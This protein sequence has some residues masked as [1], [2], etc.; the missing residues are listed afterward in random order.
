MGL[1][2]IPHQVLEA[3]CLAIDLASL[4]HADRTVIGERGVTLSGGQKQR[5]ALARAAYAQPTTLL[6]DDVLSAVDAPTGRFIFNALFGRT[7][8]LLHHTACILITHATQF[9]PLASRCLMLHDGEVI[10]YGS[11]DELRSLASKHAT[12]ITTVTGNGKL[13]SKD[14][15]QAKQQ[16]PGVLDEA[17]GISSALPEKSAEKSAKKSAG[18]KLVAEFL[19]SAVVSVGAGEKAQQQVEGGDGALLA[20]QAER[21]T[22][23]DASIDD[24]LE[25]RLSKQ[26]C[27]DG[28]DSGGDSGSD[29]G[30]D[31]GGDASGRV[32]KHASDSNALSELCPEICPEICPNTP[33]SNTLSELIDQQ[34]LSGA[35]SADFKK[36]GAA[37][38]ERL[39]L[40]SIVAWVGAMGGCSWLLLELAFF[41]G[42]RGTYV[43]ADTWLSVWASASDATVPTNG[44][45]RTIGFGPVGSFDDTRR[46]MIVWA[47]LIGCNAFFAFARTA[48]FVHGGARAAEAIFV[49]LL[50]GIVRSPMAFFD[51]TP[52]G[53]LTAR[54]AYDTE[55]LDGLLVQKGLTVMASIWWL[56]SG[57]SVILSIVTFV[58]VALLPCGLI[59]TT[60]HLMYLRS[61]VQIQRLF[62]QSQSPLVSHIE[63]S[64]AGGATIRSF[65]QSGRFRNRLM[66][67][68]D[69]AS[70]AFVA[71]VAVGRWLAVRPMGTRGPSL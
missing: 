16:S 63:E 44:F 35:A 65:G 60:F 42:E 68:N 23:E 59:Y 28:G 40:H 69:D 71:F 33:A 43:G 70:A 14:D 27:G 2:C 21:I 34:G 51:T 30:S 6:L 32:A 48:W 37:T 5:I 53:R 12:A 54:L 47:I 4:P 8:G 7:S 58:A 55:I 41:V 61:G 66:V 29:S 11:V 17:V 50:H 49:R 45:Y 1:D 67:L 13:A 26:V 3:C 39:G 18:L 15:S 56:I 24:A 31:S 57:L 36:E 22:V 38:E 62:A 52:V 10:G 19:M 64:L 25:D 46:Y 9:A 20:E